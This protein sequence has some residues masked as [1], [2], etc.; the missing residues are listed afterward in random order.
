MR[1]ATTT[2]SWKMLAV[3]MNSTAKKQEAA[4]PSAIHM[5]LIYHT[6]A[7]H[8]REVGIQSRRRC[9]WRTHLGFVGSRVRDWLG[10]EPCCFSIGA[11]VIIV[12]E[13]TRMCDE[14][15]QDNCSVL[16]ET[17]SAKANRASAEHACT[18]AKLQWQLPE[19]VAAIVVTVVG[20]DGMVHCSRSIPSGL[21]V[22]YLPD[23]ALCSAHPD[24]SAGG[25][26]AGGAGTSPAGRG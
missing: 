5:L 19:A 12:P 23:G 10:T 11:V 21:K 6:T 16:L 1:K 3:I 17:G 2:C 24:G 20:G 8:I 14:Q 22:V 25:S 26:S 15:K 9:F 13:Y 4:Y 18:R 7:P